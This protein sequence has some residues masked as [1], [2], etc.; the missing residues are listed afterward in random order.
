MYLFAVHQ[1]PMLGF[2]V[3]LVMHRIKQM[4]MPHPGDIK[5]CRLQSDALLLQL[6]F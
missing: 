6:C 5:R 1:H 3:V 4:A 2:A